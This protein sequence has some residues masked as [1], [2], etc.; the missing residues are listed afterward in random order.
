DRLPLF[1]YEFVEMFF[2]DYCVGAAFALCSTVILTFASTAI[3]ESPAPQ[4]LLFQIFIGVA[5]PAS[6]I[7]QR[8]LPKQGMLRTARHIADTVRPTASDPNRILGFAVGPIA[9]DQ[10]EDAARSV[11]RDAFD[12]ALETDM[13]VALHLDDYIFWAQA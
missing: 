13:A 3:A 8:A 10:G 9:M 11:I 12:V 6:G 4:Y 1:R 2:R 7:Y 5:E